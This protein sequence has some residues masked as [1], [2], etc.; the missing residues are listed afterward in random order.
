MGRKN[1]FILKG[2][3]CCSETRDALAVFPGGCIICV[4]G[5]A[6]GA[7]RRAP[8]RF[9]NLPVKDYSSCLVMPGLADLHMH[10]PQFAFRG[11]G[12][13]LE[14]LE[15]LQKHAFA[16][17][18]KY[19]SLAYARAAYRLVAEHLKRG[20]NTRVALFATVHAEAAR[21]LADLM[22]ESGL[23]A[24]V[25]KVN[26]DRNCPDALREK[27]AAASLAATEKWL[28]SQQ[29]AGGR[30]TRPILTPRFIP[31]CSDAL[32]A[33]LAAL[34]KKYKLPVQSHLSE[35][36]REI[37]W[38]KKLRPQSAGYAA[39]YR[40]FDLFGG[41]VPTLMAHC[42]WPDE[43]ETALMVERQVV[44][45]HCP[46][47]NANLSS[48]AAPVRRFLEAGIPVGLGS[49]VA[50]GANCSIFRAMADSIQVSKLR[51]VL[52]NTNEKALT[53]EEAFY[54]GTVQGGAFFE[55]AGL[56]AS[57]SFKSG[58]DFDAIVIDDGSLAP[59]FKLSIRDRLERAVCLSDD[60]HIKA[61]FVKGKKVI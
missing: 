56:G 59:P 14:L 54:M 39:A 53:L 25:G 9:K 57:G 22:E 21:I 4:D 52:L 49:D 5:K 16:E 48:G 42:V 60:R 46:Q 29:S 45:V 27:S 6:E 30:N 51:R 3:I 11:M 10:A 32:M 43:K 31:A 41:E 24:L 28:A 61:K 1:S 33:G 8:S 23:V 40:D 15:W 37:E 36:L 55:K 13:D 38:V 47:S 35:N 34:Q 2:D 18:A 58:F 7:Y 44:A 50:G 12:M 17:E 26:M 19:S 20:P